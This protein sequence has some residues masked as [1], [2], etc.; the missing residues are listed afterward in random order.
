M[1]QDARGHRHVERVNALRCIALRARCPRRGR[2]PQHFLHHTH[3]CFWRALHKEEAQ[4]HRPLCSSSLRKMYSVSAWRAMQHCGRNHMSCIQR[5]YSLQGLLSHTA[6]LNGQA[7]PRT[8]AGTQ[9]AVRAP[10]CPLPA[11]PAATAQTHGNPAHSARCTHLAKSKKRLSHIHSDPQAPPAATAQ[12][13]ESQ[14]GL[15][16][17]LHPKKCSRKS[18][19]WQDIFYPCNCQLPISGKRRLVLLAAAQS[20]HES[21][22]NTGLPASCDQPLRLP[23]VSPQASAAHSYRGGGTPGSAGSVSYAGVV[24]PRLS[25]P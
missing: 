10:R 16:W 5:A 6:V 25:T 19:L 12:T 20:I 2:Y 23:P 7:S 17:C 24:S 14:A 4:H 3:L 11:P 21:N 15:A 1:Q 18:V 8:A 13:S 22:I 9:A